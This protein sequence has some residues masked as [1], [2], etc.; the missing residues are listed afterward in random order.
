VIA[1]HLDF[2]ATWLFDQLELLLIFSSAFRLQFG[3]RL[4]EV[5]FNFLDFF[6]RDFFDLL[7]LLQFS[8]FLHQVVVLTLDIFF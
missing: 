1:L 8:F 3:G 7:L 6:Y 5:S 2:G 4:L